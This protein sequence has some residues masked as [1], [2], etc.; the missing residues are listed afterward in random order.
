M[1]SF[2]GKL[3]PRDHIKTDGNEEC[4]IK[5]R[6]ESNV[7]GEKISLENESGAGSHL[8]RAAAK[9]ARWKSKL[10]LDP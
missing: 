3:L 1:T 10:M 2:S 8:G 4:E 7:N 9:D 5:E 6:V